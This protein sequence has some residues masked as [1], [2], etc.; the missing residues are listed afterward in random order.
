MSLPTEQ[1]VM[2]LVIE[3]L[4]LEVDGSF[5]AATH[6]FGDASE[7]ALGLDSIDALEIGAVVK[8]RYDIKMKADDESSRNAMVC[9]KNLHAF[10]CKTLNESNV[11]Q[12]EDVA[13]A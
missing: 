10:I 1:E 7:G 8:Q 13:V 11:G 2:D 4:N 12:R 3:T 5:T 6:L 9:V